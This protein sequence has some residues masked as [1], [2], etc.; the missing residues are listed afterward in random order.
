MRG[1]S[2]APRER[3][4]EAVTTVDLRRVQRE[5]ADLGEILARSQGITVQRSGGLGSA[6]RLSLNGLSDDQVRFFLDGVPLELAGYPNGIANV[7][8][9]LVE[10]VEVYR[11]VVPIRFGADALGGAVNLVTPSRYDNRLTAS[12]QVGSFG[13]RRFTVDGRY[14]HDPTGI[15]ADANAFFDVSNN[16]YPIDV[17]APDARGRPREVEAKRFHDGYRAFGGTLALGVTGRSWAKRLLFRGF[18]STFDKEL[19]HN[20]VM[21]VPYGDVRYGSTVAGVSGRY[22]QPLSKNVELDVL[23]S[24]VR[25]WID[26]EDAGRTVYDWFGHRIRER[27]IAGEIEGIPH[28]QLTIQDSALSRTSLRWTVARGHVVSASLS[29]TFTTRKGDERIQVDPNGRDPLS[30]RRRLFAFVSGV[31]YRLGAFGK[32]DDPVLENI[33]FAKDYV[34]SSSTEEILPNGSF[35]PLERSHHSLGAGD[36]V[37]V[38]LSRGI[39][40]KA[41]YEYATRLPRPDEVFGD[42]V[43][44]VPNLRLEPEVSHNA[45]FGPHVEL[46]RTPI[47]DVTAD[48][49]GFYRDADRL[50]VLLG[51]ARSFTNQNVYRARALG[52]ETAAAWSLPRR[53]VSIDGMFT[54][55]DIRNVSS[56]GTFAAFDGDRVPNRPWLFASWGVRFR[57]PHAFGE[58][59]ALEPFYVGRYTHAFFRG[60]E[61]QGVREFKQVVDAQTTHGFGLSWLFSRDLLLLTS[62]LEVQNVTN[63]RVYDFFGVQRA[64]RAV[65]LK[66]TAEL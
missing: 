53:I 52:V 11:G 38:R 59:D 30:A 22:E 46:R 29:P 16:N 10:R 5:S 15:I 56:E 65:H 45:N 32:P 13:T 2:N 35:R 50:I 1:Q 60:W 20:T 64:G 31:E 61:S 17:E 54:Y 48:A 36:G 49:N 19:Q 43:L 7:P 58:S 51:D 62:T 24:Y 8:V 27:R 25:R 4:A 6:T 39:Y 41:S 3:S 57:I 28:D 37:R 9:N 33:A 44:V 18:A 42:G 34:F 26:F 66:I 23:G 47:G 12:Y 14:R 63:A 55:Q 40:A 21:T